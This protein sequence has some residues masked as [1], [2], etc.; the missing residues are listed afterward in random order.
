[1]KTTGIMKSLF[2]A[3]L[4]LLLFA[5]TNSAMA[6]TARIAFNAPGTVNGHS[7]SYV[8]IFSMNPD[9]SGVVQL[10]S[11][12]AGSYAPSWS[13]G[14]QYIAF[15]QN[16]TLYV[17]QAKG[18]AYGGRTFAV[19]PASYCGGSGWSSDG[20]KLAYEGPSG[21]LYIVTVDVV[22]G[23]A[24]RPVLFRSGSYSDPSWSPDGT[25]IA[26]WGSDNGN[27][28]FSIKVRDVATGAEISFGVSVAGA[29]IFGNETPQW[30][31]DGSLI[32]FAGP[33]EGTTGTACEV[34]IANADGSDIT[35]VT[36]LNSN[37]LSP[38]W[39]PDGTTIAF[40]SDVSGTPSVYKMVLGSNVAALLHSLAIGPD[41]NP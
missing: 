14:Q 7:S 35:R 32:A 17:M 38:T 22:H 37:T 15:G 26:F 31:P 27:L 11:A 10:T 13:P 39:S 40:R 36:Y 2:G 12:N 1:M 30:S 6:Q 4:P 9:G 20:T 3:A 33:V 18:E 28:P 25:R 8:Q 16:G 23:K 41:W 21:N 34:F 24:G 5:S 29:T 19:A